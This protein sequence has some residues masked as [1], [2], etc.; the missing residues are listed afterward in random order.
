MQFIQNAI[1]S[2][3]KSKSKLQDSESSV[4]QFKEVKNGDEIMVPLSTSLYVPGKVVNNDKF[5]VDLGTGYYA[6][7]NRQNSVDFLQRK[8][9]A[10]NDKIEEST[11]F[12]KSK[13]VLQSMIIQTLQAKQAGANAAASAAAAAASQKA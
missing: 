4:D 7:M 10:L 2:M 5:M 6:E 1:M 11:G 13:A 12:I 9:K 8:I 3:Q